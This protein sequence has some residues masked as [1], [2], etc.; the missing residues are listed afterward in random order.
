MTLMWFRCHI[1]HLTPTQFN[2]TL[3]LEAKLKDLERLE[4]AQEVEE[5]G[6]GESENE[7]QSRSEV[8]DGKER[9]GREE[10]TTCASL[11]QLQ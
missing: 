4:K 1:P 2:G 11:T 5:A 3:S 7:L 6:H 8:M 10:E 9:E